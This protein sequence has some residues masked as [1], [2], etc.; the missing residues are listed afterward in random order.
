MHNGPVT[1]Y[2]LGGGGRGEGDL[3][4]SHDFQGE[5]RGNQSLLTEI[6]GGTIK[7]KKMTANEGDS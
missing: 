7:K 3:W 1:S 4:A 5:R 2:H 6:K